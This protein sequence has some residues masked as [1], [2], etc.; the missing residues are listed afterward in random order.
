MKRF[1]KTKINKIVFLLIFL[2]LFG[3]YIYHFN[4]IST[5]ENYNLSAIDLDNQNL[6]SK[7]KFNNI[8]YFINN[9]EFENLVIVGHAYG[10]T[11]NFGKG[12]DEHLVNFLTDTFKNSNSTLVLTGDFVKFNYIENLEYAKNQIVSIFKNY[13][14]APGNHDL[15][16]NENFYKI[17]ENDFYYIIKNDVLVISANFNNEDWFLE[18]N[19]QE[20]IN[21]L[22]KK[23][24]PELLFL[25][26]HQIYWYTL[27]DD[28]RPNS[29]EGL[30]SL[31]DNNFDWI[32]DQTLELI[33]I[34]GDYGVRDSNVYCNI[35]EGVVY[36]AS[37]IG[38]FDEDKILLLSINN[39]N[40]FYL[41]EVNL[42]N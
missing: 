10:N 41:Q 20:K 3:Y 36:I 34:S 1:I 22:I 19:D 7:T 2:F 27:F 14:I 18:K 12:L 9:E 30:N 6:C 28:V 37:G 26:S 29:F 4:Q 17:F 5:L 23:Y 11:D 21:S 31:S 13:I 16:K 25:F 32:E 42:K 15:N 38:G 35:H 40:N 33:I 8:N 39:S 24:N